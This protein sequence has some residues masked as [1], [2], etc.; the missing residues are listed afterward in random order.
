M[1]FRSGWRGRAGDFPGVRPRRAFALGLLAGVVSFV[2][3]IYWTSTVVATFGGLATPVAIVAMLLL[4][5]YMALYP[6]LTAVLTSRAV[7]RIG[8]PGLLV[9]PAAWVA[10]EFLRGILFGGFPWVPLGNSQVTV[11]PVAQLASVLG[12]YGLSGLVAAVNVLLAMA[13][14]SSGQIGR[15]HV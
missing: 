1:L 10:T 8:S 2:I 12:V 3:A 13:L 15:A 14:V 11:L 4:A 7:S 5:I 6:A 9:A